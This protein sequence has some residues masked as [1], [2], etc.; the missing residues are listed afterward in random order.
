MNPGE[1]VKGVVSYRAGGTR[2]GVVI[3]HAK[4]GFVYKMQW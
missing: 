3:V 2:E 1:V 4:D